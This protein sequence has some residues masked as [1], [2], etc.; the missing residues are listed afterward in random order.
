VVR[1]LAAV[2]HEWPI[3]EAGFGQNLAS[4][5]A[6]GRPRRFAARLAGNDESKAALLAVNDRLRSGPIASRYSY[7]REP[8]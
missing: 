7:A 2:R 8:L 1:L 5:P 6:R 4:S 3:T